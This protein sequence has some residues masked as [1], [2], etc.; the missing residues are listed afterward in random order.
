MRTNVDNQTKEILCIAQE[1][2]AEVSQCIS[3]IFR[4]GID[5]KHPKTQISNKEHLE[6]EL[7]DLLCM[8]D[9]LVEKCIISDSSLNAARQSK[10]DKLRTWS[11]IQNL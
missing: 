2:C 1:E 7:G 8:I 3:K 4:F 6:E 10:R 11:R 9:I 5:A